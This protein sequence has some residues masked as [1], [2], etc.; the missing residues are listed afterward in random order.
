MCNLIPLK[1]SQFDKRCARMVLKIIEMN[2]FA[3]QYAWQG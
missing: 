2:G 3:V 1:Y